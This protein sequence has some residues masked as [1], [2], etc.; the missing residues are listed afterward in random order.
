M[1]TIVHETPGLIDMRSLTLMGAQAKPSTKSPIGYFGTGLK[2]AIAVLLRN[3]VPVTLWRGEEQHVFYLRTTKFRDKDF[4]QVMVRRARGLM[5]RWTYIELPF[6][7]QLGRNWELWMA[8]R[9]LHS[10]T[11]DEQ[12]TTRAALLNDELGVSGDR[13]MPGHTRIIVGP[14]DGYTD[15]WSKIGDIFLPLAGVQWDGKQRVDVER[16]PSKHLY[17]RGMRV[18]D[19]PKEAPA[20]L[21]WNILAPLELTEDRTVKYSFYAS[22]AVA[23]EVAESSDERLIRDVLTAP[24]RTWESTLDWQFSGATPSSA[25]LQVQAKLRARGRSSSASAY[26]WSR[27][28]IP[29]EEQEEPWQAR[30]SQ[31]LR[32]GLL[33]D[34]LDL[35]QGGGHARDV[36]DALD[37]HLQRQADAEESSRVP[38]VVVVHR[39]G[40]AGQP[41]SSLDAPG[42]EP[43]SS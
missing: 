13:G 9:E 22:G 11:L 15:A 4:D 36:A 37:A 42:P 35:I 32:D 27:R 39:D 2:Y 41:G 3:Q 17:W 20:M 12:G 26:S 7:T 34:F 23:R 14:H 16:V 28:Y 8:L 38:R 25:F 29:E 19:L 1:T 43:Y 31:L 18:M 21:R 10:N 30:A 24:E 6:T 40:S 33:Q 5:A